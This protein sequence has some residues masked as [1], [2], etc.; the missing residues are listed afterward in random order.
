VTR[1][2][3]VLI[4]LGIGVGAILLAAGI[5]LYI[6][7]RDEAP[8]RAFG[9]MPPERPSLVIGNTSSDVRVNAKLQ[10]TEMRQQIFNDLSK[11]VA[12]S[13]NRAWGGPAHLAIEQLGAWR[14]REAIP[15]LIANVDWALDKKTLPRGKMFP[16]IAFYPATIALAQIGGRTVRGPVIEAA[17]NT[18]DGWKLRLLG[19]ILSEADGPEIAKMVLSRRLEGV[20]DKVM[21]ARLEKLQGYAAQGLE[22]FN[23]LPSQSEPQLAD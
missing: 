5:G 6:I 7:S 15:L 19:W 23:N 22:V 10:L 21:K 20:T 1:T 16:T 2:R 17:A 3:K 18:D 11:I 9:E 14:F 8:P 13:P 12:E 4:G